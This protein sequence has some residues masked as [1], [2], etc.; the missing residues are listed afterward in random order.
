MACSGP[1]APHADY[2]FRPAIDGLRVREM[3]FDQSY[4][5]FLGSFAAAGPSTLS[6]K[7]VKVTGASGTAC[8]LLTPLTSRS[9]PFAMQ[10]LSVNSFPHGYRVARK[11][12]REPEVYLEFRTDR[13]EEVVLQNAI[14]AASATGPRQSREVGRVAG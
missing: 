12:D 6:C 8:L 11:G 9:T 5:L 13:V 14:L 1:S 10:S 4:L 2:Q 7:V 3:H